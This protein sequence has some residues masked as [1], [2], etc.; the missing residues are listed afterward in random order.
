MYDEVVR[1]LREDYGWPIDC[2]PAPKATARALEAQSSSAV[3]GY[4]DNWCWS[5]AQR[6][7]PWGY[8]L[9]SVAAYLNV[10]TAGA[11]A[12]LV[13][14]GMCVAVYGKLLARLGR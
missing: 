9:G 8:E 7:A 6:S 1:I 13:D 2:A 3:A 14:A 12:A 5:Q 11:H 4:L 10:S